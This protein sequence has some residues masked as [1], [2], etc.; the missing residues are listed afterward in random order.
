MITVAEMRTRLDDATADADLLGLLIDGAY[1]YVETQTR[2][3]FRAPAPETI[4]LIGAGTRNLYLPEKPDTTVSITVTEAAYA[5]A[6]TTA[7]AEAASDGF[8][9]RT[10]GHEGWLVRLGES[11]EWTAGYEYAVTYTHGYAV[12]GE[13]DDIRDLVAGLV[14]LKYQIAGAEGLRSE[15]IG[16]YSYTRFGDGDLDAI[17][18]AR[19]TIEAW[20]RPVLA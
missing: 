11:G 4:V 8:E 13:P 17:P 5:G 18:G 1:A 14:A 19:E 20:R 16:G 7:V 6:T 10:R 3:S 15:N 12:D 9:V 2:R